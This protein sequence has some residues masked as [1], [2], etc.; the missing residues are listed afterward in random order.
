[1][2]ILSYKQVDM[3]ISTQWIP[4]TLSI[5]SGRLLITPGDGVALF[6]YGDDG[7][8]LKHIKLPDYMHALHAVETSRNT[9]VVSHR[10]QFFNERRPEHTGVSEV[11][12]NGRV[13]RTY[14]SQHKTIGSIHLYFPQYLTLADNNHVLIAD[15]GN[16]CIVVLNKDLKLK[17]I[18]ISSLDAEPTR[19]YFNQHTGNLF[20][21]STDSSLNIHSIY[22]TE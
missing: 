15:N 8:V 13:V 16:K 14:N 2:N 5:T 3:F 18:L 17:R 4:F 12:F 6:I 7:V 10:D 20:I 11:D 22:L 19:L 9:C 21:G 1:V